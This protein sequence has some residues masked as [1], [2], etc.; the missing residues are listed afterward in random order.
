[1]FPADN[2]LNP[3]QGRLLIAEPF[4]GEEH[5]KRAVILLAEHNEQG[6][7]GFMLNKPIDLKLHEVIPDFSITDTQLYFGGPVQREQLFYIHTLGN[8][9]EDSLP[10][11]N[12]LFWLGD[13]ERIR[14]LIET[15]RAGQ[16]QVRFFVGY[17][18]WEYKQ[19]EREL[20][21][22]TWY[23]TQAKKQIIFNSDSEKI[24]ENAVRSLGK[25]YEMM[26]NFPENPSFN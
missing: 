24:W 9:V 1:M 23:V 10:I 14:E 11:G 12:G 4:M 19:L 2:R 7:I 3:K 8:L 15:E 20:E 21:E 5:F 17:S 25:E 6:S 16:D 13:F 18:G 26:V 22:K